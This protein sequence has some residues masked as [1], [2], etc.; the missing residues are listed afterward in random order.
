MQASSN[1]GKIIALVAYFFLFG[2]IIALVLNHSNR[3]ELGS[4]HVRQSL[5]I[6][7]LATIVFILVG[8]MDIFI[9]SLLAILA[10]LALW[11]LGFVSAIQGKFQ[12]VPVVG[13]Y[14]QKWFSSI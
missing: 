4:F 10:M 1:I 9:L 8:F 7:C 6:M 2:W 13:E 11:F 5:G 3:T 14:F 12:T